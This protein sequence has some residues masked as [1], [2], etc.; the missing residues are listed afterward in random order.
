MAAPGSGVRADSKPTARAPSSSRPGQRVPGLPSLGEGRNMA[1]SAA[2]AAGPAGQG[3]GGMDTG[4]GWA[5]WAEVMSDSDGLRLLD[6]EDSIWFNPARALEE[7]RQIG[8]CPPVTHT[9][10]GPL[11]PQPSA[12]PSRPEP[13]RA[14]PSQQQPRS[15]EDPK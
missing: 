1:T 5:P 9:Q 2:A 10:D 13:A 12:S 3:G 4:P 11:E 8:A 14:S 15:S 7:I 6:P